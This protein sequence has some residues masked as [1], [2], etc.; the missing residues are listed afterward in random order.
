MTRRDFL[1]RSG[2]AGFAAAPLSTW[3]SLQA[4][5]QLS[6]Q[7]TTTTPAD[8]RALVCVFL[9]GGN[10]SFGML[11]P[12]PSSF[13]TSTGKWTE[14]STA[15]WDRYK[16]LRGDLAVDKLF[17]PKDPVELEK[18]VLP[19][20]KPNSGGGLHAQ[21]LHGRM[22]RL[23]AIFNGTAFDGEGTGQDFMPSGRHAA[24]ITNVG[25]LVEPVA[26]Q[27]AVNQL[28]RGLRQRPKQIG[29]HNDQISQW[30]TC[31][32]QGTSSTGWGGRLADELAASTFASSYSLVSLDG[33]TP[34]LIGS[35][36]RHFTDAFGNGRVG[37][38][39]PGG[40]FEAQRAALQGL[41]R[42]QLQ[43]GQQTQVLSRAYAQNLLDGL[44]QNVAWADLLK[45]TPATPDILSVRQDHGLVAKLRRVAH[46]IKAA[47]ASGSPLPR[48]QLFFVTL[49]GWDHHN[50]AGSAHFTYLDILDQALAEFYAQMKCLDLPLAPYP[51][52]ATPEQIAAVNAAN[53]AMINARLAS[54][55]ALGTLHE[56]TLFTASDFGRALVPNGDGT[57]HAWGGH[58]ITLG[59]AVNG[60]NL[61]GQ[62][63]ELITAQRSSSG[64]IIPDSPGLDLTGN[65]TFI[66]SLAVDQY[67]QRMGQWF[68]VGTAGENW[69]DTLNNSPWTSV[70]PNWGS[71]KSFN[72]N[73]LDGFM[74]FNAA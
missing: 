61:Y 35:K 23:Q 63:P 11:V 34:A 36:V 42:E 24:F 14:D 33:V 53:Q 69:S 17:F 50:G 67:M 3:G 29:S 9:A 62:Y 19:L 20:W 28:R 25:T 44:D 72:E 54:T 32:P 73:D 57:D 58:H 22:P 16:T 47:T 46:I 4:L 65:G 7:S 13:D 60:G 21:A 1:R 40:A 43:K 45:N 70:L 59:G 31:F 30:Q 37:M 18:A 68:L 52:N 41:L 71:L 38:L 10:D 12:A 26:D 66:P 39:L 49:C 2:Y 48:R 8:Y 55:T 51:A 74:G 5:S 56:V 6:A 64:Q 27:N 15:Q